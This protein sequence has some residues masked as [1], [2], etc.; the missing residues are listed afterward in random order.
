LNQR[1][2]A[3][4]PVIL[5]ANADDDWKQSGKPS[6]SLFLIQN[7]F[8][9]YTEGDQNVTSEVGEKGSSSHALVVHICQSLCLWLRESNA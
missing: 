4:R 3:H 1:H 8:L 6:P 5:T 9:Q 2:L 7:Y